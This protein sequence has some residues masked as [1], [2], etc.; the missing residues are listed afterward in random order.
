[1]SKLKLE[2]VRKPLNALAP[3]DHGRHTAFHMGRGDQSACGGSAL[4]VSNWVRLSGCFPYICQYNA[5]PDGQVQRQP[6]ISTRLVGCGL[7]CNH[8]LAVHPFHCNATKRDN[9]SYQALLCQGLEWMFTFSFDIA[10]PAREHRIEDSHA[11]DARTPFA[12]THLPPLVLSNDLDA[13][14]MRGECAAHRWMARRWRQD[15]RRAGA[16]RPR[17]LPTNQ[18]LPLGDA[19]QRLMR[20]ADGWDGHGCFLDLN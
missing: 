11:V 1:M 20:G 16:I 14:A 8:S 7:K 10:L 17:A 4:T 18:Q 6:H 9:R 5:S 12:V 2:Q 3:R 19:G 13:P 15:E